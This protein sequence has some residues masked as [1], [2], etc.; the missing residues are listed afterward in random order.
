MTDAQIGTAVNV[1]RSVEQ[2]LYARDPVFGRSELWRFQT[3]VWQWYLREAYLATGRHD[4]RL[5]F[6]LLAGPLV[7]VYLVGMYGL[8]W[9]QCR[10]WSVACCVAVLSVAVVTLPGGAHWGV[11]SLS[12]MTADT[13]CLA[14]TPLL[15][16]AFLSRAGSP[17]VLWVFLGIGL[18]ANVHLVTSMNLTLIL[19]V[20]VIGQWRFSWKGWVLA[21][22]GGLCSAGAASPQLWY[23]F[24][25]GLASSFLTP[26][27]WSVVELALQH[28][29]LAV[30]LPGMLGEALEF[31]RL[32]RL[33]GLAVPAVAVMIRPERFR[34]RNLRLWGWILGGS[35]GTGLVLHGISQLTGVLN[36][37]APPVIDFVHALR[38]ALLPLYVLMA[39]AVVHLLRLGVPRR[40]V[41]LAL[42]A[43]LAVWLVPS[44][45][46]AVPRHWA[47]EAVKVTTSEESRPANVH[48]RLLRRAR[49]RELRAIGQWLRSHTSTSTVVA[50]DEAKLRLWSRRSLVVCQADLKCVYHLAPHQLRRWAEKMTDQ[51]HALRPRTGLPVQLT[52]VERFAK[53]YAADFVVIRARNVVQAGDEQPWVTSK[54]SAW[55]IH[56]KLYRADGTDPPPATLPD[57][58]GRKPNE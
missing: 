12:S 50:C 10:S 27:D 24:S 29:R 51:N 33:L 7:F 5:P 25:H 44:D 53:R 16:W 6:R 47:E 20:T 1:V 21:V 9:R 13:V 54:V 30:L 43:M 11:G 26:P 31:P 58:S 37:S 35:L 23:T 22:L 28:G 36:A 56:W 32:A 4:L 45:N 40:M 3:P 49:D 8:L 19:G 17:A 46:F 52:K 39:Q 18:L 2:D 55:G 57:D 38:F 14:V 42:G 48:R 15:V 41:R 34:V